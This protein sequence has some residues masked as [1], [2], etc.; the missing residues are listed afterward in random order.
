MEASHFLL[1]GQTLKGKRLLWQA[2][3]SAQADL[4]HAATLSEIVVKDSQSATVPDFVISAAS[5]TRYGPNGVGPDT[6]EPRTG[7]LFQFRS[8][9]A[10]RGKHCST[11]EKNTPA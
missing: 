5:G 1:P 3:S 8:L 6:P 10:A 9:R 2:G 11:P 4:S 7:V